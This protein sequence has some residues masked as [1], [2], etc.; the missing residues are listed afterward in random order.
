MSTTL[1]MPKLG[2]VMEE[3]TV[4]S[5]KVREGQT[6]KEGEIVLEIEMDKAT[7]EIES[8]A[9]GVVRRILVSEGQTVPVNTP[10]A[11]IE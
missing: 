4:S 2:E 8:P 1:A 6:V 9:S 10:L 11:V 3:G 5:W 7:A